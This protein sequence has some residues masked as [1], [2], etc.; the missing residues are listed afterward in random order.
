MSDY[1]Y[2]QHGVI[3]RLACTDLEHKL[4]ETWGGK[5]IFGSKDMSVLKILKGTEVYPPRPLLGLVNHCVLSN[6]IIVR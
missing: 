5:A 6:E 1:V 3:K 4:R 2:G